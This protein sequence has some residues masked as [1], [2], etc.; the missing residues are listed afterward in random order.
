ME[1]LERLGSGRNNGL[2]QYAA[3]LTGFR[4]RLTAAAAALTM[5]LV[6]AAGLATGAI[7][8]PFPNPDAG[9]SDSA[10]N[11]VYASLRSAFDA[12]YSAWV[13]SLDVSKI[14]LGVL[15]HHEMLVEVAPPEPSLA[16]AKANADRI[17][18][19]KVGALKPTLNGTLV[20]LTV[21]RTL[22]GPASASI[23]IRQTSGLRPSPD[24]ASILIADSPGEPLLLPGNRVELLLQNTSDGVPVIQSV[25]GTYFL[26][27]TGVRALQLNPFASAVNGLSEDAL[28]AATQ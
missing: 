27:S 26:T 19:G 9:L 17:I 8:G 2:K 22:K 1:R 3:G 10:R 6:F 18:V 14:D 5:L 4:S 25:S 20:T 24:W 21:E 7:K 16:S 13:N 23:T 15:P 12:R 11:S 28:V